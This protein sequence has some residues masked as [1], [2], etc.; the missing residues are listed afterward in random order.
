MGIDQ[1]AALREY[2]WIVVVGFIF[3]FVYAF[4]IGANDVANAFASTVASKSLTLKQAVLAASIFEFCGAMFLGASVTTTIR[5]KIFSTKE[6]ADEP[7]ILLL[8]FFTSIFTA[9]FMLLAA[10]ALGLP[11]ST[12]HTVVGT[13][14]GFTI[15]AKGFPSVAWDV[16][17][18]IFISWVASPGIGGAFS[19]C[20]FLFVKHI[21]LKS[22][23]P[24]NRAYY[25]FPFILMAGI[26]ID[27]FYVLYKGM[28]NMDISKDFTFEFTIPFSF[29][30][31]LF[32]GIIWLV[33][34][35]PWARGRIMQMKPI[36]GR[37]N[38]RKS[39]EGENEEVDAKVGEDKDQDDT[40][41]KTPVAEAGGEEPQK[42]K[43]LYRMFAD[44]TFDQDI[45]GQSMH[46]NKGAAQIWEAA[47]FYDPH[48]EH[49]FTF[50]QVFTACLNSFAHG[51]NDV[52][53]AIGP[54]SGMLLIYQ[55]GE[56]KSKAPVQKWILGYGG[57]GLVIGLALYG[58]KIMK[59]LGYK[60]TALSPSRGA[61]AELAASLWVVTASFKSIPVSTTQT[62]CGAVVG[63]GLVNGFK[64]LQWW[65][66]LRVCCG[67]VYIFFISVVLSAGVFAMLAYSPSLSS[68]LGTYT[69]PEED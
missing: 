49:L 56:I 15:V 30:V 1:N 44:A 32:C 42:K 19:F 50:V 28:N 57:A 69:P 3:G 59:S 45:E 64:N 34:V 10:T 25:M 13:L 20:F 24:F 48:A 17:K 33:A 6:Y 63:V 65:F 55:E 41:E 35:G 60:M 61:C 5:S 46:E 21:I 39:E 16:A 18:K 31:G 68:P 27:L 51:A 2:L 40:A 7:E 38:L 29:G 4:G 36:E 43:S 8:G 9:S 53:N 54:I 23:D 58:Y 37:T 52:A 62:I 47:E 14:M 26:G 67:W 66:L 22:D 12:T 11:V